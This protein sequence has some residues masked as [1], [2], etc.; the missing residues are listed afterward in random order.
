MA[1]RQDA[2]TD[3]SSPSLAAAIVTAWIFQGLLLGSIAWLVW[4]EPMYW[5]FAD[6]VSLQSQ[7]VLILA[8]L[9]CSAATG[10]PSITCRACGASASRRS[11]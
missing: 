7:V 11:S 4:S 2:K 3:E 5:V 8:L 9:H 6:D 10:W 1:G